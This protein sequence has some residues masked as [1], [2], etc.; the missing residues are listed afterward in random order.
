MEVVRA[1]IRA[2]NE[3]DEASAVALCDP[4]FEMTEAS[5]LP[6]A[7]TTSGPDGLRRYYAGWKRNWSEWDW[8]E[9]EVLDMPPNHVL[10]VARLRLRGLRSG[11]WV[12]HHWAY[13]FSVREGKILRQDGFDEKAQAI[14]AVGRRE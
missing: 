6:G 10:V 4:A 14:E 2:C 5:S 8:Q 7:A 11:A 13:L 3:G 1:W 9:E 12:E